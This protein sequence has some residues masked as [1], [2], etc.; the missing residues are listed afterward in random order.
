MKKKQKSSIV[1]IVICMLLIIGFVI[2]L[3]NKKGNK[4]GTSSA[5]NNTNNIQVIDGEKVNISPNITKDREI[6]GLKLTNIKL[7][8]DKDTIT[9]TANVKNESGKDFEGGKFI[10][11]FKDSSNTQIAVL[12][13]KVVKIKNGESDIIGASTTADIVNASDVKI[14]LVSTK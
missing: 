14:E 5:T 3:I 4:N 7:K 2:I 8:T 6:D 12:E 9:Y 11:R 13:A 1:I 10:L